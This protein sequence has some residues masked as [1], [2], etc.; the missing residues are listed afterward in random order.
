MRRFMLALA[1]LVGLAGCST[2]RDPSEPRPT[3]TPAEA[4]L[5]PIRAVAKA[6]GAAYERSV[7][8][9]P[10]DR[11]ARARARSQLAHA[12]LHRVAAKYNVTRNRDGNNLADAED[13]LP[14]DEPLA[15]PAADA[16]AYVRGIEWRIEGDVATPADPTPSDPPEPLRVER[17]RG[18][19][20][21]VASDAFTGVPASEWER[22]ARR[23]T[24]AG[25][26]ATSATSLIR[27]GRLRPVRE[28][29]E[30]Y[31]GRLADA[32]DRGRAE[33][34]AAPPRGPVV[35]VT[36][37]ETGSPVAGA[38]VTAR[39]P[40]VTARVEEFTAVTDR[41]GRTRLK[42]DPHDAHPIA[43]DAFGY[44]GRV[45]EV[46]REAG[47]A[48]APDELHITVAKPLVV[49]VTLVLPD[50]RDALFTVFEGAAV[51][52]PAGAPY[53]GLDQKSLTVPVEWGDGASRTVGEGPLLRIHL[54]AAGPY[55]GRADVQHR[56]TAARTAAGRQLLVS[57]DIPPPLA[58]ARGLYDVGVDSSG[59]RVF[60]VGTM[61]DARAAARAARASGLKRNTRLL[62]PPL[63]E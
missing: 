61:L 17:L 4:Y 7:V 9:R 52:P 22:L 18:G 11:Y 63:D 36:D 56:V 35:V 3:P 21:V 20:I 41:G 58:G 10:P 42:A 55:A 53:R 45:G 1:L 57:R 46:R 13:T 16:E 49:E 25:D 8:Y 51:A 34:A 19:W 28:V 12:R 50:D 32:A 39:F 23:I 48:G 40:G 2:G 44:A 30:F 5:R 60:V 29:N 47:A 26:A 38:R 33:M 15:R 6:D 37:A 14:V 27:A 31:R 43:V 54:P 62:G 24:I 59:A